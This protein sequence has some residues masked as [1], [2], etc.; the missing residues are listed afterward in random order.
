RLASASS[1]DSLHLA[2]VTLAVLA[3]NGEAN[4][5]RFS[6]AS[7]I[8]GRPEVHQRR[9]SV[10]PVAHDNFL[11]GNFHVKI[12]PWR[13]RQLTARDLWLNGD[14]RV[15]VSSERNAKNG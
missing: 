2:D 4:R 9:A 15:A 7:R 11:F 3:D 12:L 13:R 14:G 1:R 8:D 6:T 10:E 5:C